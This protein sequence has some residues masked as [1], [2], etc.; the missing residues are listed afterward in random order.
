MN[1]TIDIPGLKEAVVTNV[2]AVEGVIH[3]H[4][5]MER[6]IHRC[7]RCSKNEQN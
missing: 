5:E 6:R 1:I 7:P 4:A 3:I 2:E